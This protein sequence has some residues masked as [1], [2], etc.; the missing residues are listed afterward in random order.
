MPSRSVMPSCRDWAFLPLA[1]PRTDSTGD[2]RSIIVR[3]PLLDSDEERVALLA[4]VV[5][6]DVDSRVL[7][8]EPPGA[9]GREVP[10]RVVGAGDERD[11][12]ATAAEQ[13]SDHVLG[14]VREVVAD[15]DEVSRDGT[16]DV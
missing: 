12:L 13:P 8:L 4:T 14:H 15:D 5:H 7:L 10:V 6:H 2:A 16:E 9:A 1:T 11:H 3:L